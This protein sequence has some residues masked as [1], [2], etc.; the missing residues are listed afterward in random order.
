MGLA[1]T[2]NR[3]G[4]WGL[5]ENASISCKGILQLQDPF[6]IA[7]NCQDTYGKPR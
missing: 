7:L 1:T 5:N 2:T 6:V 3:I 4:S